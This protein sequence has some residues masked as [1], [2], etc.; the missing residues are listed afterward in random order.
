MKPDE[1]YAQ[2]RARNKTLRA[3]PM[4]DVIQVTVPTW[5]GPQEPYQSIQPKYKRLPLGERRRGFLHLRNCEASSRVFGDRLFPVPDITC[6]ST[7]HDNCMT[8]FVAKS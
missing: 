7:A 3:I 1:P 2:E 6:L 4:A 5:C 8:D